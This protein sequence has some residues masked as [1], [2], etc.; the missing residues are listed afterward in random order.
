MVEAAS[1]VVKIRLQETSQ[2]N[3][4]PVAERVAETLIMDIRS[5]VMLASPPQK[6]LAGPAQAVVLWVCFVSAKPPAPRRSDRK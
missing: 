6:Q 2:K 5:G 1:A 4:G 3:G